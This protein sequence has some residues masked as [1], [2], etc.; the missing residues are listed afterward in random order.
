MKYLNLN[1]IILEI[2]FFMKKTYSFK[3]SVY[4]QTK[5][6]QAACSQHMTETYYEC[7]P[8]IQKQQKS[9]IQK[10]SSQ[11]LISI[12]PD[13]LNDAYENMT[14][15]MKQSPQGHGDLN[16]RPII[17]QRVNLDNQE[18]S[19]RDASRKQEELKSGCWHLDLTGRDYINLK[20][21]SDNLAC[22]QDL[23]SK[24]SALAEAAKGKEAEV[25]RQALLKIKGFGS[26]Y[27]L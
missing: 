10:V 5:S 13:V 27:R 1:I 16:L 22:F 15:S 17:M 21:L 24:H 3:V 4:I 20:P 18:E 2:I 12:H 6:V 25:E 11:H 9:H 7:I 8:D 23:V 19:V 26:K 14:L